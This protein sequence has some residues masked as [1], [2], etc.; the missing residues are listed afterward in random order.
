M[1]DS[2]QRY[3]IVSFHDLTPDTKDVCEMFLRDLQRAG[4]GNISLLLVPLPDGKAFTA[5]DGF[6][7][8]LTE[9]R[10]LGHEICLH[11][12]THR[13]DSLPAKCIRRLVGRFYTCGEGEFQDLSWR[14]AGQRIRRGMGLFDEAG[15]PVHGFVP[16]AWLI[17]DDG[18][19]A[20]SDCGIGYLPLWGRIMFLQRSLSVRAPV[21]VYSNRS[22]WRR[23]VSPVWVRFWFNLNRSAG[24]L[25]LAVHPGDLK[26]DPISQSIFRMVRAVVREREAV[27]YEEFSRCRVKNE[28]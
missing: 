20:A 26:Y 15:F 5:D 10:R 27:T 21:L 23:A 24:G 1:S 18:I 4:V 11:G 17:N 8:W 2:Q 22:W 19:T 13:A 6:V 3:L 7:E 14:E 16:P 12:L 9:K 25:R 28:S